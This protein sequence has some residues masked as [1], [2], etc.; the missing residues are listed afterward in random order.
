MSYLP[1]SRVYLHVPKLKMNNNK[2]Y[3]PKKSI[4]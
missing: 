1:I 2:P 3:I 4:L